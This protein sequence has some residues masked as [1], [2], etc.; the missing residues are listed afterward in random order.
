MALAQ[1]CAPVV[2]RHRSS[3]RVVD[4]SIK[5]RLL[6]PTSESI[7]LKSGT[8]V[9]ECTVVPNQPAVAESAVAL[10]HPAVAECTV[11]PEQ[12]AVAESTVVPAASRDMSEFPSSPQPLVENATV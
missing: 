4:E 12:P 3:H 7:A 2:C 8:A 10:D 9:A 5:S 11:V 6:D 1:F